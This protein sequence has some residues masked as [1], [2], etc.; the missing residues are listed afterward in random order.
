MK[1]GQSND[2]PHDHPVTPNF[3]RSRAGWPDTA[4]AA[5]AL[6]FFTTVFV[7]L[8]NGAVLFT[9]P[10]WTDELH[11]VLLAGRSTPFAII[12]DLANGADY[13]PPL[14]H[15]GTWVVRLVFG[16]LSPTLLRVMSLLAV[17][18]AL[19]IVYALARRHASR[20]VAAAAMFAVASH[21]LVVAHSF[22]ARF[23]GPWLL[24]A[25]FFAWT[26]TLPASRRRDL[27]V[28]LAAVLMALIHWYGVVALAIMATGACL[29]FGRRWKDGVRLVAPA[30]AGLVAVAVCLPL[31]VGQRHALTVNTWVPEFT[32]G[33]LETLGRIYWTAAIPALAAALFVVGTLLSV[34]SGASRHIE[35]SAVPVL[36]DPG[37][38]ALFA[39]ALMPLALAAM[40]VLGQPSMWPRYAIPAALA[41]A[42][43]VVLA[44]NL[45]GEWPARTFCLAALLVWLSNFTREAQYKRSFAASVER[46][47]AGIREA[48]RLGVPVVFQS[49]HAMYGVASS[50]WPHRLET[51]YLV[52]PDSTMEAIFPRG[53]RYDALNRALRVER[54]VARVHSSRFGFPRL[55][56][57]SALDSLSRFV[58][59]ASDDNLPAGY[60]G[61]EGIGVAVFPHHRLGRM[62]PGFLLF[63]RL[64]ARP[65]GSP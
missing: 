60:S 28:A 53:G 48:E 56:P 18:G 14:L 10:F 64:G 13:A 5:V 40:S 54:D 22:E 52:L 59:I 35:T 30:A 42:P 20:A 1:N 63:D 8:R 7:S 51:S 27:T 32:V 2:G 44:L 65:G 25:A 37:M 33:Q 43:L 3:S 50:D 55:S 9:R 16:S 4:L 26:L 24:C 21:N 49:M 29:S 23:Y 17:W 31:V 45:A 6:A 62:A 46:N 38:M 61:V 34:R 19:L 15:L 47:R 36:R 58:L 41:W 12:S 11:T 39:L 57:Q